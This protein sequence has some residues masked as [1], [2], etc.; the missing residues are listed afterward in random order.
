LYRDIS[1]PFTTNEY[2][3]QRIAQVILLRSREQQMLTWRGNLGCLRVG[4]WETVAVT[5][6]E[7]G[8]SGKVFRCIKREVTTGDDSTVV[9]LTLR[10]EN[11]STYTDPIL[12]DYDDTSPALPQEPED[13]SFAAPTGL[14]AT[15]VAGGIEFTITPS[16][17][18]TGTN[19]I[20]DIAEYTGISPVDSATVVW[21]GNATK[22]T[23]PKSDTTTRY[24]WVRTRR[25][26]IVSAWYPT[27]NGV[28]GTALEL[29]SAM[30]ALSSRMPVGL[31]TTGPTSCGGWPGTGGFLYVRSVPW[32][33]SISKSC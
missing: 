16:E 33:A 31:N 25:N 30:A 29:Y 11:S 17:D 24:Y 5:V 3:A 21:S 4:V 15:G 6:A 2:R 1:L 23:V 20:Y 32:I 12:A 22:V 26:S 8:L 7:L 14:T 9:E 28:A 18:S 19:V 13:D 27:G 10:E